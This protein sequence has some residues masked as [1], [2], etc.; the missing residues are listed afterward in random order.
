MTDANALKRRIEAAANV[1][2]QTRQAVARGDGVDLSGLEKEVDGICQAIAGAEPGA[3]AL[4]KPALV[5]L[6]DDLDRLTEVLQGAHAQL[7]K[8]MNA[9]GARRRATKAY[10][11]P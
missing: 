1:I 9:L 7:R 2:N 5:A 3:G 11:Q 10:G 8:E 6:M 4:L